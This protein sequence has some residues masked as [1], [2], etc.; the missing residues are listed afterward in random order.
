MTDIQQIDEGAQALDHNLIRKLLGGSGVVPGVGSE[1]AVSVN[2]GTLG[3]SD[4]LTVA[5]GDARVAGTEGSVASTSV[6]I[7]QA[8]SDPRKDVVYID[9]NHAVQV[10]KGTEA[11][12]RPANATGRDT[13]D[14]APPDLSATTAAPLA[15]VWV[16]PAASTVA[17]GDV[18][19]R[20]L[21]SEVDVSDVVAASATVAGTVDAGTVSL[22]DN[23]EVVIGTGDDGALLFDGTSIIVR[24]KSGAN[25]Y[26]FPL[27]T[28]MDIS[29]HAA[30]HQN[31][32]GD[33]ISVAG[34]SGDLADAQ[35]PKA[36][37]SSHG[38]GGADTVDAGDLGGS[39]GTGGQ[40][41]ETDG[42]AAGWADVSGSFG[43][44]D[45]NSPFTASGTSITT[46]FADTFDYWSVFLEADDPS[47]G[48]GQTHVDLQA[49]GDTAANYDYIDVSGTETTGQA[50]VDNVLRI[51]TSAV[52]QRTKLDVTGRWGARWAGT[53]Q[54]G[55][56]RANLTHV[57]E[58]ASI[59][60]PLS[61][62]TF[63]SDAGATMDWRVRAFGIDV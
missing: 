23:E 32:G 5:A 4:T 41:L 16:D 54:L 30:R 53:V 49:N 63:I 29:A 11:A 52:A 50:Q 45:G 20:R 60:S 1:L 33:E 56:S 25:D 13:F 28:A 47:D 62:L 61:S 31:G 59:S 37:A 18:T 48:A 3:A 10:A 24:D 40:V 15:E 55:E 38:S 19:D 39:S 7:D 9:S 57:F 6:G 51:A 27:G 8:S 12:A 35:D 58:N 17:A 2:T 44:E 43:I 42:T 22:D 26:T 46:T 36:H 21:L 34:L 14:P